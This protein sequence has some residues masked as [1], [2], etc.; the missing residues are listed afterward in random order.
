MTSASGYIFGVFSFEVGDGHVTVFPDATEP[1]NVLDLTG[2]SSTDFTDLGHGQVLLD[3]TYPNHATFSLGGDS[4]SIVDFGSYDQIHFADQSFDNN[5]DDTDGSLNFVTF[6]ASHGIQTQIIFAG[7]TGNDTFSSSAVDEHFALAGG[8]NDQLVFNVSQIGDDGVSTL[9]EITTGYNITIDFTGIVADA[10]LEQSITLSVSPFDPNDLVITIVHEDNSLSAPVAGIGRTEETITL[11]NGL[12]QFGGVD[13]ISIIR[14]YGIDTVTTADIRQIVL[15]AQTTAGADCIIGYFDENSL[16]GGAGDDTLDGGGG[17]DTLDGG[18]GNNVLAGGEGADT[19]VLRLEG[20]GQNIITDFVIGVDFLDT[21]NLTTAELQNAVFS[22]DVDGNRTIT[23]ADGTSYT[24]EGVLNIAP[25]GA[26]VVQGD[27]S[28]GSTLAIEISGISD[29][30][31]LGPFTF[32]WIRGETPIPGMTGGSYQIQPGDVG[33][34]ITVQVTYVDGFGTLEQIESAEGEAVIVDDSDVVAPVVPPPSP[35]EDGRHED[36]TATFPEHSDGRAGGA[37][38]GP[39]VPPN[40]S[41]GTNDVGDDDADDLDAPVLPETENN[42]PILGDGR[43]VDATPGTPIPPSAPGT[44]P[45]AGEND[46]DDHNAAPVEPTERSDSDFEAET[47]GRDI[48]LPA[49]VA[50]QLG[51]QAGGDDHDSAVSAASFVTGSRLEYDRV[52]VVN[53]SQETLV[54]QRG[55]ADQFIFNDLGGVD[56]AIWGFSSEEGDSLE[57]SQ[58]LVGFDPLTDTLDEFVS[59]TTSGSA[60]VVGIDENGGGDEFVQVATMVDSVLPHDLAHLIDI[61]ALDIG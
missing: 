4:L 34:A 45:D 49:V 10:I 32:Q 12:G 1:Q 53:G 8:T 43:L 18:E 55:L 19:F 26:P 46:L 16:F 29:L 54:A 57:I 27:P 9:Q 61:G 11:T 42:E 40:N 17:N 60:L 48:V 2:F 58:L 41:G 44:P 7:T 28:I 6:V 5:A 39:V 36:D 47:E 20:G 3:P 35:L 22:R 52:V 14:E 31:G 13:T 56:V 33:S 21:S 25:T 38:P 50:V 59:L 24:L 15:D 37:V 51:P 23:F 30:D